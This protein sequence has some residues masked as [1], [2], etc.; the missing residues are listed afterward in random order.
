MLILLMLA[1]A[2]GII[3]LKYSCCCMFILLMLAVAGGFISLECFLGP[4]FT[5]ARWEIQPIWDNLT[6]LFDLALSNHNGADAPVPDSQSHGTDRVITVQLKKRIPTV[7]T[8]GIGLA[9]A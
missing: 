1:V 3:L 4:D 8:I 7:P 2:G 9:G 6:T 5:I